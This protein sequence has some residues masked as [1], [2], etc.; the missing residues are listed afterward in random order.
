MATAQI[1]LTETDL[2][3]G[4][5]YNYG[6]NAKVTATY[7]AALDANYDV[8]IS[9]SFTITAYTL[10]VADITISNNALTYNGQDQK[11]QPT[12]Q[13]KNASGN[14][15]ELTSALG[16]KTL[17][18]KVGENYADIASALDVGT[19]AFEVKVDNC[20]LTQN[21]TNVASYILE[22]TIAQKAIT[23]INFVA[24][25]VY[26]GT[27]RVLNSSS[28]SQLTSSDVVEGETIYFT[29]TYSQSG[30]GT[31]LAITFAFDTTNST[32]TTSNY[33]LL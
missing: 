19:Y 12:I 9:G 18:Q 26:D 31:N 13:I 22:F 3:V 6:D 8:T 32:S 28:S 29:G 33:N 7:N 2:P 23:S 11:S 15:V 5:Y 17:K 21:G 1:S 25:K 4:T 10:D 24:N 27:N 20:Q 14:F 16:T 30:V